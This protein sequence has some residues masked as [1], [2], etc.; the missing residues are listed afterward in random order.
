[1]WKELARRCETDAEEGL[2]LGSTEF[3]IF[4]AEL[5]GELDGE[6][7]YIT[8]CWAPYIPDA[9]ALEVTRE[10]IF[11]YLVNLDWEDDGSLDRIRG[12]AIFRREITEDYEGPYAEQFR[13]MLQ[14]LNRKA[15]EVGYRTEDYDDSDDLDDL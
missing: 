11:N 3:I 15:A 13:T 12:E 2:D 7:A 10:S 9:Y 8:A 5:T 6:T 1:M 4:V 14:M